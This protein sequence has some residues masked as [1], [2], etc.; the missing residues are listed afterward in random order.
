MVNN[1]EGAEGSQ[2]PPLAYSMSP[3]PS[4]PPPPPEYL[5]KV[6]VLTELVTPFLMEIAF[7][8]VVS[9]RVSG[10]LYRVLSAVGWLP[11]V[12]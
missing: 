2:P 4:P 5:V 1:L 10:P 7:T 3:L 6:L 11:L 9:V 8:T 12:V